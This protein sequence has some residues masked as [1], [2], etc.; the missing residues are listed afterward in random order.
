[1][2]KNFWKSIKS[3]NSICPSEMGLGTQGRR[4]LISRDSSY[5][6]KFACL[7][8]SFLFLILLVVLRMWPR[9]SHMLSKHS[10]T[11]Q[12]VSAKFL[13][14]VLN[15]P[16]TKQTLSLQSFY[17]TLPRSWN[18]ERV[19]SSLARHFLRWR[20]NYAHKFMQLPPFE[21]RISAHSSSVPC[22]TSVVLF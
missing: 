1:M 3:I 8:P 12:A 15:L 22:P 16:L 6:M 2:L 18:Y 17:L 9:T 5:N 13:R 19:P 4:K 10:V 20:T 11:E 14:L 21:N 7:G